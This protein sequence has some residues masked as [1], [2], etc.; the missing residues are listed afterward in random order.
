MKEITTKERVEILWGMLN[1]L[2]IYTEEQLDEGLAEMRKRNQLRLQ[3]L[4]EYYEQE[5]KGKS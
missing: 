1:R 3:G 2:G 5:E 4:K